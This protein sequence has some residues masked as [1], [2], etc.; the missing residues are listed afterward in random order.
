MNNTLHNRK[1]DVDQEHNHAR[2]SD[3]ILLDLLSSVK[4]I[5]SKQ[6]ALAL[7]VG[8][9]RKS[10][11]AIRDRITRV[12]GNQ[13]VMTTKITET[14]A[15]LARHA[16]EEEKMLSGHSEK[17]AEFHADLE[18]VRRGFPKNDDGERDPRSHA[19]DHEVE[20]SKKKD[21][22]TLMKDIRKW[23]VIS[24]LAAV[25]SGVAFLLATG[26]K[27]ELS[28]AAQEAQTSPKPTGSPKDK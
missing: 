16:E 26:T 19:D 22:S 8:E 1:S 15:Y 9:V 27:V 3:P 6:D 13:E 14:K 7:D 17:L 18:T 10:N 23:A 24:F 11:E 2:S 4:M 25:V 12:E 5:G 21:I 20:A 28:K